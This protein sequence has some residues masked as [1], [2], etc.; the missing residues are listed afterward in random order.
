MKGLGIGACI[1]ALRNG[2]ESFIQFGGHGYLGSFIV[3]PALFVNG[4]A[5]EFAEFF[6]LFEYFGPG[7][8]IDRKRG[9]D[10][11]PGRC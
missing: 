5:V 6:A 8:D 9:N 10:A 2:A 7:S 11:D 4:V 3:D 1:K